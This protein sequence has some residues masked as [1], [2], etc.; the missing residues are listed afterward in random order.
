[1][2]VILFGAIGYLMRKFEYDP[3]PLILANVLGPLMENSLRQSMML[4]RGDIFQMAYRPIALFF[5][6]VA[7]FLLLSPA[8]SR[9]IKIGFSRPVF[10]DDE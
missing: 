10:V 7:L 9:L 2:I 1:L 4:F 5:L 8:V 3:A 6:A